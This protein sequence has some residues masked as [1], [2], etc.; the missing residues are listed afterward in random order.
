MTRLEKKPFLKP[1]FLASLSCSPYLNET[2][3]I[4]LLPHP[5]SIPTT[6]TS[7]LCLFMLSTKCHYC[8]DGGQ[9]LFGHAPCSCI[10]SLLTYSERCNNLQAADMSGMCQP[11]SKLHGPFTLAMRAAIT[12]RIGNMTETTSASLQLVT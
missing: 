1:S 4:I 9:N 2:P 11:L 8:P 6:S 10:R 5:A 3:S 7:P 12:E